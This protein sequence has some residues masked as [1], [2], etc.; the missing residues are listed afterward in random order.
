MLSVPPKPLNVLLAD[1]GDI[2][3]PLR[4][5]S[6]NAAWS[7]IFG[8]LLRIEFHSCSR[9]TGHRGKQRC[10]AQASFRGGQGGS[11]SCLCE[12]DGRGPH[13]HDPN[14]VRAVRGPER[15]FERLVVLD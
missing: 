4:N 13:E 5:M 7:Q 9:K 14:V 3:R 12:L 15:V 8:S 2:W 6:L 11:S 1:L 10:D